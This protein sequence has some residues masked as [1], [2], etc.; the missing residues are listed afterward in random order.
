MYRMLLG[1]VLR[2][3]PWPWGLVAN[4]LQLQLRPHTCRTSGHGMLAPTPQV[5]WPQFDHEVDLH[6]H[7]DVSMILLFGT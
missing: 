5:V 4:C 6:R 2:C 1:C 3:C 7:K